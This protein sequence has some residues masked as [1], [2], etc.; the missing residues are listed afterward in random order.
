[1][2]WCQI[3]KDGEGLQVNRQSMEIP[4]GFASNRVWWLNPAVA[5]GGPA[6]IA[7]FVAYITESA[8]YVHFWRTPKYFDGSSLGLLV[9]AVSF[10]SCGCILG[11]AR[12]NGGGAR[13][14]EDWTLAIPWRSVRLLFSASFFLTVVAYAIW[15]GVGLKH[16]LNLQVIMNIIRGSSDASYYLRDEYLPTIPGVTTGTQ[17]GL[18]VI[19]LAVP[20]GFAQGW[21]TVRWQ[22]GTVFM[23]AF[24]RALLNSER[25]AL[26][27]VL[28]PFVVSFVGLKTLASR[29]LRLI[30]GSAPLLA[31]T[32]LYF[33]F[34]VS[35]Y[36]RSWSAF[37][38]ARETSF[39]SFVGLRLMG[40]YTTAL[41]NGALLWKIR[42]P[43]SLDLSLGTFM[44]LWKFP[45]IKD[46]LPIVLSA[47]GLK[48][49]PSLAIVDQRYA[50]VLLAN[51]NPEFNNATGIYIPFVDFGV[52][53]GLL[54]WLLCGV[55]CGYLY[56]EF[57]RRTAPGV[58]LYPVLYIALIEASRVLYW[59]DGRFFPGMFL[60]TVS[61]I[62]V[63]RKAEPAF[64]GGLV[65]PA[66]S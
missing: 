33:F 41:N 15:F 11:L 51:A 36:F 30:V 31:V 38:A 40:Y 1:M 58:F 35:E 61:V 60:L 19:A 22:C 42:N 6:I 3:H 2:R 32:L 24:F 39:W 46:V 63:F 5:F 21:R 56:K 7:G 57:S 29:R 12:R 18:T 47:L 27:E 14:E 62:F 23:L 9:L 53:G 10:F 52:A 45:V 25:L 13:R 16:G 20:L 34:G 8:N 48:P 50:D 43:L 26:L 55:V 59:S 49:L 64:S 4:K 37:Y 44:F 65:A 54:Y 66:Q 17:F 28:V